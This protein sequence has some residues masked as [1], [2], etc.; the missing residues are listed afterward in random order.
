MSTSSDVHIFNE[1]SRYDNQLT[2]NFSVFSYASTRS[3]NLSKLKSYIARL[4][5]IESSRVFMGLKLSSE[6]NL[7]M[8]NLQ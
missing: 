1:C 4:N 2:V 7:S 3:N 5:S 6:P 8:N